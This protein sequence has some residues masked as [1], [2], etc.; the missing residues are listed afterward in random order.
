MVFLV[1]SVA[2]N[3]AAVASAQQ[4]WAI[5]TVAPT[6]S[7]VERGQVAAQHA[8]AALVA[9]GQSVLSAERARALLD[10]EISVP[11]QAMPDGLA[12]R[13]AIANRATTQDLSRGQNDAAVRAI[14]PLLRQ[15]RP[16]LAAMGRDANASRNLGLLCLNLVRARLSQR[17]AA[18]ALAAV[19]TCLELVPGLSEGTQ[20]HP[21]L[22]RIADR[23]RRSPE[24]R[25]RRDCG[26]WRNGGD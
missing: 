16:Y 22:L 4:R 1:V 15:S 12:D 17:D 7:D 19:R 18:G 2:L 5:V 6:P 10:A 20:Q 21:W 9:Q 14:E 24:S 11:M 13:V 23:V 25:A 26:R 8:H 3:A